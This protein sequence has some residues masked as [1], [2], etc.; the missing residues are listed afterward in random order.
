MDENRDAA[1]SM[2]VDIGLDID[3]G[4]DRVIDT[5]NST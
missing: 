5:D 1:P 3:I 2:F 4:L